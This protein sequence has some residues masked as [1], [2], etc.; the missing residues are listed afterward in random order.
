MKPTHLRR[1]AGQHRNSVA[2]RH[3]ASILA[4]VAGAVDAG[5]LF[6][7]HQ[8]TSHMSGLTSSIADSL[9]QGETRVALAAVLSILSFLAG[10]T[11]STVLIL[12]ARRRHLHSQYALPL[13]LEAGFLLATVNVSDR[14]SHSSWL[15]PATAAVLC[16]AVGLQHATF[17]KLLHAVIRTTHVTGMVTDIG[18]ELG[19]LL[20]W[21]PDS[22]PSSFS[23]LSSLA[24]I[25]LHCTLIGLFVAGGLFGAVSFEHMRFLFLLPLAA[26]L[27]VLAMAPIFEDIVSPLRPPAPRRLAQD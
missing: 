24:K 2:N 15:L 11:V 12:W 23:R 19:R 14:F 22:G 17:T 1:I 20:Y 25:R 5:G 7:V 21:K 13:L 4:L 27:M 16:F 26:I 3:L 10:S 18:I 6:A 9:A 8:Y